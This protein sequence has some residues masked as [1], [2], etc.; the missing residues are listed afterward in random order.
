MKLP[1]S[2][3]RFG[4]FSQ[5]FLTCTLIGCA[6]FVSALRPCEALAQ[7]RTVAVLSTEASAGTE[8]SR[9]A[10][11]EALKDALKTG[12][13]QESKNFKIQF[14]TAPDVTQQLV[15]LAKKIA[16]SRVEVMVAIDEGA[17]R[18]MAGASAQ[19]PLVFAGVADPVQ[20]GLLDTLTAG[21]SHITGV[22]NVVPLARQ[23]GVIRQLVSGA[24]KVGVIYNPNDKDS[25]A[26]VRTLQELFAQSGLSMVEATAQ[27]PVDV[28]SAARSLIG[29]VDVF[30]T[31]ADT[32]VTQSY[33]AL[34]KVANDAKIPLIASDA[35]SVRLGAIGAL[36]VLDREL[37]MQ[38]G[39][40]V[41]RIL[42]G[43]RTVAMPPE[44][45]R[46]QLMLS[47]LAARKQGVV[48]ADST[49][50]SAGEIL[51]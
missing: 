2:R 42:R 17:A 23:V 24:R 39:R 34:V 29:R 28:G 46:P 7:T 6:T 25:L 47:T 44:V 36:V 5:S 49:L 22:L 15:G 31:F 35:K 16:S 20:A 41:V 1:H 3:N 19:I 51:K 9:L 18:A 30:F 43:A 38:A 26:S 40:M 33:P 27:R 50:K 11:R 8:A 13:F 48:L 4:M 10:I 32:S 21:S 37:G 12:G 45:A 14:E